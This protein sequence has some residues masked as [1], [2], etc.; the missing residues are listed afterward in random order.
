MKLHTVYAS[1]S[2]LIQLSLDCLTVCKLAILTMY[3]VSYIMASFWLKCNKLTWD[4]YLGVF[5]WGVYC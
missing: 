2:L 4:L 1:S 5:I 3:P